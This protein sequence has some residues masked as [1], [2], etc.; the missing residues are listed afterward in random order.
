MGGM[1]AE[2]VMILKAKTG[3]LEGPVFCTLRLSLLVSY[4]VKKLDPE[5]HA[6]GQ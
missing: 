4:L 5:E 1:E 3:L 2:V 6:A